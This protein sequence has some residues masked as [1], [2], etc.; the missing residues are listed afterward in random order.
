VKPA[1][2][3]SRALALWEALIAGSPDRPSDPAYGAGEVGSHGDDHREMPR[4]DG[5]DGF[6]VRGSYA[7]GVAGIVMALAHALAYA[8]SQRTLHRDVQP[9]N[10]LMT[11]DP[12]SDPSRRWSLASGS[13]ASSSGGT[14]RAGGESIRPRAQRLRLRT[15]TSSSPSAPM[16]A[17]LDEPPD[18]SARPD[19]HRL[20]LVAGSHAVCQSRDSTPVPSYLSPAHR[21]I[22]WERIES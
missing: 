11:L 9:G 1:P 20:V 16:R 12:G 5:W 10:V 19:T 3:P 22:A 8:H 2:H 6:P 18:G 7:Q 17:V 15:W 21:R 13:S 4:G 14:A